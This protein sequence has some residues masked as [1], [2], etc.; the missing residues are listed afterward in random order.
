MAVG[1]IHVALGVIGI[2]ASSLVLVGFR[3]VIAALLIAGLAAFASMPA[4]LYMMAIAA[5][6]ALLGPGA[7]SVDSRVFGRREIVIENRNPE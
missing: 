6:V 5:A 7:F 4:S 2:I 1:D 3:T